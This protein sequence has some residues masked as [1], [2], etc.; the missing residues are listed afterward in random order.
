MTSFDPE[1]KETTDKL[2]CAEFTCELGDSRIVYRDPKICI[3]DNFL[4]AES[5][6]SICRWLDDQRERV[7][8]QWSK[9]KHKVAKDW[10]FPHRHKLE[11]D[12]TFVNSCWRFVKL[13]LGQHV[14]LHYD[15]VYVR[16][17]DCYST[18][19]IM[20][21]LNT[22][23]GDLNV[24]GTRISA[25]EGRAVIFHQS[26]LHQG[27]PHSTP[28]YFMRSELL[29]QR[30]PRIESENDRRAIELLRKAY[31][32]VYTDSHYAN[33]LEHQ[34]FKLSPTLENIVLNINE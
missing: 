31:S 20:I 19:T 33:Q 26:L 7:H 15:G 1:P 5:C 4:T 32:Y 2:V 24:S 12:N 13:G 8:V 16:T 9:N 17:V 6:K 28:K 22:T 30:H 14:P 11:S 23:D 27:L 3:I 10:E 25:K 21:Y 34:A 18:H 29:Y